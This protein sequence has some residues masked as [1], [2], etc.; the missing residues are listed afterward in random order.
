M[1]RHTAPEEPQDYQPYQQ[2]GQGQNDGSRSEN[3]T[4][5]R[6][7]AS[8]DPGDIHR[9]DNSWYYEQETDAHQ[10]VSPR[11]TPPPPPPEG[12][13][14]D[15]DFDDDDD[16]L[17]EMG[18]RGRLYPDHEDDGDIDLP[19]G[20]VKPVEE[21]QGEGREKR[22]SR[23]FRVVAGVLGG[24]AAIAF[25]ANF[26]H[27]TDDNK[28]NFS[29]DKPMATSGPNMLPVNP[30]EGEPMDTSAERMAHV[31]RMVNNGDHEQ[32][33]DVLPGTLTYSGDNGD[34]TKLTNPI[35]VMEGLGSDFSKLG[36]DSV[37]PALFQ[38][39]IFGIQPSTYD[40]TAGVGESYQ[41]IP[42]D[43]TK[44]VSWKPAIGTKGDL[45]I[46]AKVAWHEDDAGEAIDPDTDKPFRQ[47]KSG[48]VID[49]ESAKGKPMMIGE[50]QDTSN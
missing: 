11:R 40:P 37:D 27:D 48:A 15:D 28:N 8:V 29:S 13:Y 18:R 33:V 36:S 50:Q 7:G 4:W 42:V 20:A 16:I 25:F 5:N 32:T 10:V 3:Y 30:V 46:K 26:S 39:H 38:G 12:H 31:Q 22:P 23:K 2:G 47:S 41:V 9:P 17:A 14:F 49:S 44:I 1:G 34:N 35:I 43:T 19:I 45:P 6:E 21:R 24:I